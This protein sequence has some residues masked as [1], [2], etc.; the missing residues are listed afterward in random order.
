ME[1]LKVLKNEPVSLDEPVDCLSGVRGSVGPL[2]PMQYDIKTELHPANED[3]ETQDNNENDMEHEP[4]AVHLVV[5][6]FEVEYLDEDAHQ[7]IQFEKKE[8]KLEYPEA[9]TEV[10]FDEEDYVRAQKGLQKSKPVYQEHNVQE[11]PEGL[12]E[13]QINDI[14]L[15]YKGSMRVKHIPRKQMKCSVCFREFRHF[16]DLKRHFLIHSEKKFSCE[17]CSK[18]FAQ[19]S[20]L[21]VHMLIHTGDR[22]FECMLCNR[23]FARRSNLN[24]HLVTHTGERKFSCPSC[25]R[26]FALR[27]NLLSHQPMIYSCAPCKRF[28]GTSQFATTCFNDWK[29]EN[30]RLMERENFHS[31]GK[32]NSC[33]H[34]EVVQLFSGT[35]PMETNET[36]EDEDH[37]ETED[38]LSAG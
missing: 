14:T 34:P 4:E 35:P 20:N 29:H 3:T 30:Q 37:K 26:R 28:G 11:K 9:A 16:S 33:P 24:E 10:P 13:Q 22:S 8:V 12:N 31:H 5:P 25:P 38:E 7:E 19:R 36:S 2:L 21:K 6:K 32:V 18:K 27:N 15:Q 17:V 1:H 23:K